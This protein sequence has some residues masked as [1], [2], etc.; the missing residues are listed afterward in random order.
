MIFP[1][2]RVKKEL[3]NEFAVSKMNIDDFSK[4]HSIQPEALKSW[5]QEKM[6]RSQH[7]ESESNDIFQASELVELD[8]PHASKH[9]IKVGIDRKELIT[10]R[11]GGIEIDIPITT[12]ETTLFKIL[13]RLALLH[14]MFDFSKAR[15]FLRPGTTDMRTSKEE[16]LHVINDLMKQNPFSGAVFMFCNSWRK[17]LKLIWWET[18]GFWI[19]QKILEKGRWPWPDT[20][21]QAKEIK[22]DE[23]I[24][25]LKGIDF[26]CAYEP[27]KYER[28]N[29][30]TK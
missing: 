2:K 14:M 21:E 22:L 28:L 10:V 9:Q 19:A 15:I 18:N 12:G 4:M 7:S 17:L 16:L 24:M 8:I 13:Q 29:Q 26:F 6:Y 23:V 5:I 20:V 1:V 11:A 25:L 30:M 3:I 27:L